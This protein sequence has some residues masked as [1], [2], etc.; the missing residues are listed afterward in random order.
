MTDSA[1]FLTFEGHKFQT[2][3]F[4][5]IEISFTINKDKN[6]FTRTRYN[7]WQALGDIGGFHDGLYLLMNMIM[8]PVSVG[9][10][11]NN[12]ANGAHFSPKPDSK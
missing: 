10:F 7:F 1:E 11:I 2:L 8:G 6:N 5:V 4:P 3:P 9:L 12:F